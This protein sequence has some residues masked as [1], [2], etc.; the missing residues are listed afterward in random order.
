M[1]DI[2]QDEVDANF[3]AFQEQLPRIITNE[4]NRWA[5]M[6]NRDCIAFYDTFRDAKTAGDALYAD[7]IFSIQE[8][9]ET[10]VDLGWF[11]HAM[12]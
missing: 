9:T 4:R 11:S 12:H 7:G 5:L 8:V 6:K 1:S 2:L 10:S 3:K